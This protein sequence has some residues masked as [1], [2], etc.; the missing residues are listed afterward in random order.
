[1]NERL[2]SPSSHS[3]NSFPTYYPEDPR[4]THTSSVDKHG[5]GNG[6]GHSSYVMLWYA[7]LCVGHYKDVCLCGWSISIVERR[8]STGTWSW[9][10]IGSREKFGPMHFRNYTHT[11]LTT[12]STLKG[13]LLIASLVFGRVG[14]ILLLSS[15][16]PPPL[17]DFNFNKRSLTGSGRRKRLVCM[18]ERST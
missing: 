7:M 8:K 18:C 6:N 15:P 11:Q 10:D 16:H 5:I 2:S 3:S 12:L 14:S 17:L 13:Q 4:S 1:M 9:E